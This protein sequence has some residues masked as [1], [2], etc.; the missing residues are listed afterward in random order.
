M[1]NN[2][3][4]VKATRPNTD[5]LSG[6]TMFDVSLLSRHLLRIKPIA[7][8]YALISA[9]INRD[10]EADATD[11]VLIQRLIL[12]L[13]PAFPN[14]NSWRFVQKNYEFRDPTN[15]FASDFPEILAVPNLTSALVNGDFVAIK[16][17]D[18]NNSLGAVNSTSAH[19]G[20]RLS[21]RLNTSA[22]LLMLLSRR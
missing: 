11:M 15:P 7:S 6:V 5:W 14:N 18:V 13:I 1:T 17:G 16:V 4:Q 12:R 2:N 8:P 3:I 20:R 22:D 9:D 21:M 19:W 10:G